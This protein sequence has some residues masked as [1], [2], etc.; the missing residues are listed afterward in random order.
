MTLII[1]MNNTSYSNNY[2]LN[3]RK[4][5]IH[6]ENYRQNTFLYKDIF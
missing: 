3:N 6:N 2:I 5:T 4:I 1:I